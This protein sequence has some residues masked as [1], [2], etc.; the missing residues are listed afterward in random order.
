MEFDLALIQSDFAETLQA[1]GTDIQLSWR[2]W[3]SGTTTDPV[4]LSKVGPTINGAVVGPTARTQA[5][6][7]FIHYP[8]PRANSSVQQFQ[9][10]ELGDCIVD[11]GADVQLDGKDGLS[12]LFLDPSGQPIDGQKWVPKPISERLARTWGMTVAGVS[13]WRTVV[14]RKAT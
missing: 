10:I 9:E 11:F 13:I 12:F 4:T 14:L 1:S 3:P 6:K 7:G 8:E 2:E 5:A